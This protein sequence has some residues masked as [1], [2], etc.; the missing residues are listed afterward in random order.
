MKADPNVQQIISESDQALAEEVAAT[1][2]SSSPQ[3]I[4]INFVIGAMIESDHEVIHRIGRLAQLGM[5][6]VIA[7]SESRDS[8]SGAR[9]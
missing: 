8:E 1:K 7:S 3:M 6:T 2:A 9:A 4:A 5:L